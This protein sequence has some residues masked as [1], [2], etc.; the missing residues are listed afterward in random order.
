MILQTLMA[1]LGTISFSILFN[2]PRKHY[3]F[4]GL[5]GGLGWLVYLITLKTSSS[6]FI[7][8]FVAT[9]VLTCVSRM[10]SVLRKTPTTMFLI[11]GIFTLVPGAGIYYT[12]YHFF[13]NDAVQ[14]WAKGGETIKLALSISLGIASAFS[15]P[16]SLFGWAGKSSGNLPKPDDLDQQIRH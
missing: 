13:I 11:C 3:I 16:A 2:V 4:C 5:T 7:A 14:A 6:E 12:A 10:L 9:V 8:T 1:F 15:L